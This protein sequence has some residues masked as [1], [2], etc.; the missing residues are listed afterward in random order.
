M[1]GYSPHAIHPLAAPTADG[2][3]KQQRPAQLLPHQ[4]VP[5]VPLAPQPLQQ[6]LQQPAQP[7]PFVP[8]LHPHMG[9][10]PRY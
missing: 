1:D 2:V 4:R 8:Q 6:P 5:F 9:F 7:W 3:A 10:L